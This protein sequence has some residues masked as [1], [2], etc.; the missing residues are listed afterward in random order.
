MKKIS[1]T[2]K[3]I[4]TI[5]GVFIIPYGLLGFFGINPAG[6]HDEGWM[7]LAGLYMAVLGCFYIYPNSKIR[8]GAKQILY[9]SITL[10]PVLVVL[11]AAGTTLHNEGFHSFQIQGGVTSVILTLVVSAF[12]PLSLLFYQKINE[13][14]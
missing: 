7:K 14:F 4:A 10:F 2:L 8:T 1:V 6:Y 9:Y 13:H 3:V 5:V 11:M 12:A